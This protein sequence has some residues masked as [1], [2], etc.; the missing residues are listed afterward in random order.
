M[1]NLYKIEDIDILYVADQISWNGNKMCVTHYVQVCIIQN[2][3]LV[4][5]YRMAKLLWLQDNIATCCISITMA[6]LF[7]QFTD[8]S[9][10]IKNTRGL[11]K[12]TYTHIPNKQAANQQPLYKR[13]AEFRADNI[14]IIISTQQQQQSRSSRSSSSNNN[15]NNNRPVPSRKNAFTLAESDRDLGLPQL[16]SAAAIC[17]VGGGLVG[18]LKDSTPCQSYAPPPR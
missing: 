14:T 16:V 1:K 2:E 13:R 4:I 17:L 5:A 7:S 6:G 8:I 18:A 9:Q 10:T 15:T 3:M 12:I 11:T